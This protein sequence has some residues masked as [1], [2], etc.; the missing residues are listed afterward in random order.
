L[1]YLADPSLRREYEAEIAPRTRVALAKIFVEPSLAHLGVTRA[2]DLGAGTGAAGDAI[3]V[4]FGDHVEIVSVDQVPGPGILVADVRR[5]PRPRGVEGRFDLVVAGHLLN[6]IGTELDHQGRA[7]MRADLV[8]GWCREL[9]A[10]NG[11]CILLEPA[12]R[13]TSR[14]LLG[15]R[16]HLIE[17]GLCVLAPCF[18]TGPCP[19]L[20]RERD[21]CHDAAPLPASTSVPR[22]GA[23]RIDFSY[24]VLQRSTRAPERSY[25][26]V[27]SDVIEE[28]GRTRLYVCGPAGRLPV[29][30]LHRNRSDA[31]R[32]IDE[33]VRGDVITL[34]N[35]E[36]SPGSLGVP[37]DGRVAIVRRR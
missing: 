7:R 20:A 16:D 13:E 28:K 34:E 35:V 5:S 10:E 24:L 11:V 1:P 21:W 29:V 14:D 8:A 27:V 2:L 33:I 6:E 37:G 4:R 32:A 12:L 25:L 9:L 36:D 3:R 18:W 30:R 19:A 22:S 31:N 15:V 26:R 23:G 17:M